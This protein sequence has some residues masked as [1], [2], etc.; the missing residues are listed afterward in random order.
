[1]CFKKQIRILRIGPTKSEF[2]F[3]NT[4][5]YFKKQISKH[6]FVFQNTNACCIEQICYSKR[7]FAFQNTHFKIQIRISKHKSAFQ[8]T[9][10]WNMMQICVSKRK[11]AFQNTNG[12]YVICV[13]KDE[14]VIQN[15]NLC[16]KRRMWILIVN[17]ILTY[18]TLPPC[19]HD[20]MVL[21]FT[22]ER[23]SK[24]YLYKLWIMDLSS[25][26]TTTLSPWKL[27]HPATT[28]IRCYCIC[29]RNLDLSSKRGGRG[30]TSTP[31]LRYFA[32]YVGP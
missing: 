4:N 12:L 6:K 17:L 23:L 3:Q 24:D 26:P 19:H 10:P 20:T 14:S 21:K 15:T 32:T 11:F 25:T 9:N 2:V 7:K 27:Q 31:A 29:W 1:M 22:I 18:T 30:N 5:M 13:W 28:N 8:N 16:F